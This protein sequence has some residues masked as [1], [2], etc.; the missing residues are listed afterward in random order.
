MTPVNQHV[1]ASNPA[2]PHD[3][4]LKAPS[5][6]AVNLATVVRQ[7]PYLLERQYGWN[8][9]C[10]EANQSS[11]RELA[12]NRKSK[13]VNVCLDSCERAV[14]FASVGPFGGIISTDTDNR[15]ADGAQVLQ[16]W[17]QTL[18]KLLLQQSAPREIDYLSIDVEGA[19]ERVFA[20]V[21]MQEYRFR[22]MTVERPCAALRAKLGKHGYL[23]IKEIPGYDCFYIHESFQAQYE[24][25]AFAYYSKTLWAMRWKWR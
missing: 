2:A 16:M 21:D 15:K 9:L 24:N 4:T 19:E 23:L 12:A 13:C 25:N 3:F 5:P 11:F 22:C 10:I 14:Q 17:T 20:G 18:G 7:Y 1:L 8:G 6:N